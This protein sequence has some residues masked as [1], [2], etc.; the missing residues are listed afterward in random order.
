MTIDPDDYDLRE[1]RR[2]A[3][4][5]RDARR[6]DGTDR[7]ENGRHNR[8]GPPQ[9]RRGE[10]NGARRGPRRNGRSGEQPGDSRQDQASSDESPSGKVTVR[11]RG[12]NG[13]SEHTDRGRDGEEVVRADRIAREFGFGDD[14]DGRHRNGHAGGRNE[15]RPR[16]DSGGRHRTGYA[17]EDVGRFQFDT[18]VRER[19]RSGPAKA[20]RENQ[21]EH[22]L[23]HETADSEGLSKP[24]LTALPDAYAAE[25]LLFDWL[26][27]LVLK[28]GFKRT[29]DALRYYHTVEWLA[30]EVEAELRD[31]LVG[32][33]GEVSETETFDVD[34]HHLSLVYIA[35]L[36]S[37]T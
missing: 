37:M 27:F 26:E 17:D 14:G 3:D 23:V 1:L 18:E 4:D 36:A 15:R 20:L 2:I 30:A 11:P 33:S 24:Y 16:H 22:L 32:F 21:L 6:S 19:P 29:L 28:G 5:R 8:D 10:S 34:D 13:R 35:R 31:Y 7:A 25:R 12:G 9:H